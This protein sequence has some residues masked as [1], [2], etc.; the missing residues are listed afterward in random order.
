M[1][2]YQM[3]F[4]LYTLLL[5]VS[6]GGLPVAIS[7]LVAVRLGTGDE[8]GAVKVLKVS[9][10]ALSII[11]ALGAIALGIS[12]GII[13]K[14]QGNEGASPA[15]I[16]IAPSVF[17]VAVLSCFRGYYQGRENM[18]PTAISQLL[19]QA[20]KLFAGLWLA[21]RLM[22]RGVEYAVL[23]ALLGV[24]LSEAV[25]TIAIGAYYLFTHRASKRNIF[26]R[27]ARALS[28]ESRDE[29]MAE[30]EAKSVVNEFAEDATAEL[31]MLPNGMQESCVSCAVN[32][33]NRVGAILKS[34]AKVAVPVTFGALVLPLTQVIDSV[35][36]INMLT[37][38]GLDSVAATGA[39][40][41]LSG[42]VTTL[43]N[44]PT[45][46]VFALSAVLLPKIA[47]VCGETEKV[48]KEACFSYKI[49][50][51]AGLIFSLFF[52]V[53]AT[54]LINLLYSR[55]LS[56]SSRALAATLLRLNAIS[57]FFVS[58]IQVSTA[59]LQGLN[60][61]KKPA[62]NLLYGALVKVV[63]TAALLPVLGIYGAA[64][65]TVSCYALTAVLDCVAVE[66]EIGWIFQGR[67]VSALFI[68][69]L[70]FLVIA[71]LSVKFLS[72]SIW[73]FLSVL[74]AGTAFVASVL[75]FGWLDKSE[76]KRFLPFFKR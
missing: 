21:N 19:E 59:V 63:L 40:G 20:I 2:L 12:G 68:G 3:V 73:L 29:I 64:I 70:A 10:V 74:V 55:G 69:S 51:A 43:I 67:R 13:A 14:V 27:K 28:F 61:A 47:K 76:L 45:V 15:Y 23:G 7:R 4:P 42:T 75:L 35:L 18:L 53:Y 26:H 60:K 54:P 49:C 31:T 62:K 34:I 32:K 58:V 46:I 16:G 22:K 50:M 17:F 8:E 48:K 9:V 66:R 65:G 25:A 11:G 24:S 41:L 57:V 33:D 72:L 30:A 38:F 36:I 52:F 56:K 5:T 37:I 6:S 1:G 71:I 44:V 39:Y